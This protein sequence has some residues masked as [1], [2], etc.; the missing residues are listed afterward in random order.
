MRIIPNR[1]GRLFP[2]SL[3][4]FIGLFQ[5]FPALESLA[6]CV[7]FKRGGL[8]QPHPVRPPG[9]VTL[10][11]CRRP[12]IPIIPERDDKGGDAQFPK[13]I[14][15]EQVLL[16]S[17]IES[18]QYVTGYLVGLHVL[19]HLFQAVPQVKLRQVPCDMD[20]LLHPE[21]VQVPG[22]FLVHN[23]HVHAVQLHGLPLFH[24][25]IHC[26]P[27]LRIGKEIVVQHLNPFPF[28]VQFH[29]FHGLNVSFF[30]TDEAERTLAD[31]A[32]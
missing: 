1:N 10:V 19:H 5:I 20:V 7:I 12:F 3:T 22:L 11:L 15:P 17:R 16:N 18:Y 29:R 8:E 27:S 13:Y 24:Q 14:Q 25:I 26:R 9:K 4:V 23:P 21:P 2:L 31:A 30:L 32:S 6:G 28:R